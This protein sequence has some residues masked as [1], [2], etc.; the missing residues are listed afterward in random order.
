MISFFLHY[1]NLILQAALSL[2][3]TVFI[4]LLRVPTRFLEGLH[5]Y[6][7]PENLGNDTN[8]SG[9][10]AA[11][12]R[13]QNTESS[14]SGL[15]GY[16][17]LSSRDNVE[18]KKK[19]RSKEK[20]EFDENNAQIFRLPLVD[21]HLQSR[22]YFPEYRDAFLYSVVALSSLLLHCFLHV[23][24]GSGMLVSG[25]VVPVLLGFVAVCKVLVLLAKVSFER[26]ASKRS[27][28]QI[29]ILVGF[30]GFLLV[31]AIVSMI[32]P[33]AFDFKLDSVDGFSQVSIAVLLG[34]LT[35]FLFMPATKSARSFWL[36]TDQLRC[37]LSI[38]SCGWVTR[39][40][41][42]VNLL[43]IIFTS[44]LWINPLAEIL[45]N[46][47][48]FDT[49]VGCSSPA[50]GNAEK[51]AGNVGMA[52]SDFTKLRL[53]CL[54]VSGLLQIVMLRPN[55]QMH[56]NEAV[57][58]WY[59][60]L[61][62]SRVPDLDFSRAKIFLHNYYLCLVVLQFFAPPVL[63]LIFLGLSRIEGDLFG[64]IPFVCSFVP[65]SA[66]VKE[67]ALFIAWWIVFVWVIFTSSSL[68]LYR[69]GFSY[70]S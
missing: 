24:E 41:L 33:S 34:C 48:N 57:L 10:R 25:A 55:L 19:N 4:N 46:K 65:C 64:S 28:K 60:R 16:K 3:V 29:S 5:T 43:L 67:V 62:A 52:Q 18:P 61:H 27:E 12:R 1:D 44:V 7:H 51:L 11:I 56:M 45:V 36:G 9:F 35:G 26:S 6:I 38:I 70:I 58:S 68:L 53:W 15:E 14:G 50:T 20:F 2:C 31:L 54:L 40:L 8:Q 42:H 22:L 21:S 32:A 17:S 66:F 49:K 23:P 37:N 47:R 63:V 30:L 59:Q 13:P 39:M 69:C